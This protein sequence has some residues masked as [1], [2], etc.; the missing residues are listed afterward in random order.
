MILKQKT[1]LVTGGAGF[2]GSHTAEA[3]A[4]NN[5]VIIFDNFTSSVLSQTTLNTQNSLKVIRG[6]IRRPKD[7]A[8]AMRGVDVVFH[9]AVACVRIS[10]SN[11]R[12]V[13]DVNA[14]GTLN[15][16]LAAKKAGVK[17]F[18]YISSSEVYGTAR[19]GR[20]SET[21]SIIP[22]T[23]YGASKYIG[24]LYAKHFN[25]MEGFPTIIVRPFNTYGPRSHFD[26]VYGEVIPRF[27]VRAINGKQP[28]IFGTG[29]QTRDFTYIS[30]TVT[31][32]I[33]AANEDKLLGNVINIARGQEV[34]VITIAQN[35]CKLTG[36]PFSPLMKTPRPNDVARHF[37]DITKAKKLLSFTPRVG[38]DIGLSSY[39]LWVNKS[40]KHPERLLKCVSMTNW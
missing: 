12:H 25:D 28:I 11:E 38:I 3:L 40:Y 7:L 8:R 17:R 21:H 16:L 24:E 1:I 27:T 15:T 35:I 5:R 6:D 29:H 23:V 34:S 26:G 36:L 30:D 9:F 33:K 37:A 22:T 2:I 19:G 32:I 14:T 39:I 31:G 4:K 13:H 20:M 18:I 10:L